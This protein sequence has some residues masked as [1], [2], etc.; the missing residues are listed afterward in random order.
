MIK[1]AIF[2]WGNTLMIDI[3]GYTGPMAFW[4]KVEKIEGIEEILIKL[5]RNNIHIAVAS[6]AKD[7]DSYLMKQ[8]FERVEL[9]HYIDSFYTSFELKSR[10]PDLEFFKKIMKEHSALPSETIIIGDT[11]DKD[12]FPAIQ[13]KTNFILFDWQQK[14]NYFIKNRV[15]NLLE[16]LL[17]LEKILEKK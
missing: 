10:K 16:F 3:P 1:L 15:K 12:I 13:L 17:I 14:Y 8:A 4:E 2:D 9:D 5:K 7:S 6:N 11:L